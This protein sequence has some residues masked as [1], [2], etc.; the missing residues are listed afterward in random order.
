MRPYKHILKVGLYGSKVQSFIWSEVVRGAPGIDSLKR[1]VD[2]HNLDRAREDLGRAPWKWA[3]I[4]D[5]DTGDQ[6]V[7][8]KPAI[9]GLGRRVEK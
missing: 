5:R 6:I 2:S 3:R 7:Y 9:D 1:F 8:Y 4:L